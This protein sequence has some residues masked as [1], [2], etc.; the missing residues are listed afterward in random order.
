MLPSKHH[1]YT[2][3]QKPPSQPTVLTAEN[4]GSVGLA[5]NKSLPP[6]PVMLR[7]VAIYLRVA[8]YPGHRRPAHQQT[9]QKVGGTHGAFPSH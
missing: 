1:A 6:H 9:A 2:C 5:L 7:A 3:G 8:I 4:E